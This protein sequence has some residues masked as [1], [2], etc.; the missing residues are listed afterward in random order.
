[1]PATMN[2]AL[3]L[4]LIGAM[5][6]PLTHVDGHCSVDEIIPSYNALL[7]EAKANHPDV[8]FLANISPLKQNSINAGPMLALL[9]QLQIVLEY[10]QEEQPAGQ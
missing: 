6:K 8:T 7:T 4:R 3:L 2:D 1:M 5:T 9:A 10:L